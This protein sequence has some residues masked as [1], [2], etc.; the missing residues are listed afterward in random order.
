MKTISYD[1]AEDGTIEI[2]FTYYAVEDDGGEPRTMTVRSTPQD[3]DLV[4]EDK[5]QEFIN[6]TFSRAVQQLGVGVVQDALRRAAE[7]A[8]VEEQ[9]NDE[10]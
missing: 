9:S 5:R 6:R 10:S 2:T 8:E 3:M 1:V 4:A 7:G